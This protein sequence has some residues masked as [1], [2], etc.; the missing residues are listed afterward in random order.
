V[1]RG[2]N[3][4]THKNILLLPESF[5]VASAVLNTKFG[6]IIDQKKPHQTEKQKTTRRRA[7]HSSLEKK[8]CSVGL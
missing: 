1:V 4:K 8:E 7:D 6:Q 3:S 5:R 2:K